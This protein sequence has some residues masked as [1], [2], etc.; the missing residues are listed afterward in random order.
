MGAATIGE[1]GVL[2]KEIAFSGDVLNTT[3]RIQ[4]ECNKYN[5]DL[6]I[7]KDLLDGISLDS[8]FYV[9]EIGEIELRGKQKKTILFSIKKNN[10]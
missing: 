8:S 6:L 4:S 9:Q 10:I 5:T 3:A 2:K 1:I 7:S